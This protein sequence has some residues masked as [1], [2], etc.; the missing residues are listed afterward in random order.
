PGCGAP[1]REDRLGQR[2]LSARSPSSA[3]RAARPRSVVLS[4]LRGRGPVP[5]CPS[6]RL[7]G[8]LRVEPFCRASPSPAWSACLALPAIADAPCTAAVRRLVLA[9]LATASAGARG[10][11]GSLAARLEGALARRR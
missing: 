3:R 9:R 1:R 11:A 7:A 2:L 10:P 5:S 6:A 8:S 4:L